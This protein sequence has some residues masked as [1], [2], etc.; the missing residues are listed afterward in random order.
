MEKSI[1]RI[2]SEHVDINWKLPYLI[3]EPHLYSGTGFFINNQ[4]YILTCAHVIEHSKHIYIDIPSINNN[5]YECSIVGFCPQFDIALL[6]TNTYKPL[7][8]LQLGNS[9]KIQIGQEVSVVGYPVVSYNNVNNL[10]YTKGIISGQQ[11]GFIQTD[12]SMNPGN[13]G[14]PLMY[15]KKVIGINSQKIIK[16]TVDNVGFSIPINNYKIIKN[17]LLQQ[18]IVF[19]PHLLFEYNYTDKETIKRSIIISIKFS[20][21]I[22]RDI[23]IFFKN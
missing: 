7:S 10:K 13:S 12:S 3:D 21:F 16:E 15:K 22:S 1:V 17:D 5:K 11:G 19:R 4:G 9:S 23:K 18:K 8:Y 6:R 14:G 20:L 2:I